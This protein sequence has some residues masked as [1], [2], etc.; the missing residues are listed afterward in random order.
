MKW[1]QR[2]KW[3]GSARAVWRKDEPTVGTPYDDAA[4][5]GA[6]TWA[7]S[8]GVAAG[9]AEPARA[10]FEHTSAEPGQ[11]SPIQSNPSS[12][13]EVP[14][15]RFRAV[16]IPWARCGIAGAIARTRGGRKPG[17]ECRSLAAAA[18]VPKEFPVSLPATRQCSRPRH[19]ETWSIAP[20]SIVPSDLSLDPKILVPGHILAVMRGSATL[21]P[22][23]MKH[24][25][26]LCS[27]TRD[28]APG[29]G[30]AI[31]ARKD[32]RPHLHR[33]VPA[34]SPEGVRRVV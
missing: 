32:R 33:R 23:V 17:R 7:A 5:A 13:F 1:A 24:V 21:S 22:D 29:A 30:S 3:E 27:E 12:R 25:H 26:G 20:C 4:V 19:T 18:H 9:G 34:A 31:A 2:G 14:T 16:P 8:P 10:G 15:P 11:Q 28:D 6:T